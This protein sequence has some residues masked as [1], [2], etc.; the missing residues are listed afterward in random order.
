MHSQQRFFYMG[1]KGE[2][3]VDQVRRPC[4]RDGFTF[5]QANRELTA[6][7]AWRLPAGTPWL[8]DGN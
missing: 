6:V 5:S 8:F 2:L 4:V 1:H 7:R 3:N